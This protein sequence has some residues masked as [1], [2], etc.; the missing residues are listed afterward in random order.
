MITMGELTYFDELPAEAQLDWLLNNAQRAEEMLKALRNHRR[1]LD[2][3]GYMR[4][5]IEVSSGDDIEQVKRVAE[6][7]GMKTRLMVDV[8]HDDLRTVARVMAALGDDM[9]HDYKE[10]GVTMAPELRFT[11]TLREDE[12]A[13]QLAEFRAEVAE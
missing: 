11:T 2:V 4:S 8:E 6:E 5:F 7:H 12:I 10:R 3:E 1:N 13:R 9:P